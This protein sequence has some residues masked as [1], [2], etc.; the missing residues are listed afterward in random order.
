MDHEVQNFQEDVLNASHEKPVLVDFWAA[1]CGPCQTLGPIL[2]KLE[3][4]QSESWTLVKIDTDNNR[5]VSAR[6]KIQGIPAVKLFIDGEVVD[7]FTG[8]L[9]EYAVKQWLEKAIP[10]ENRKKLV[11]A[12]LL[13]GSDDSDAAA[14]I[15]KTVLEDEPTNPTP[16]G[17]LAGI[18]A[19]SEPERATELATLARTGE[20]RFVQTADAILQLNALRSRQNEFDSIADEQGK[21]D[22][23]LALNALV[24]GDLDAALKAFIK[25]IIQNRYL[26]DDAS[27]KAC[28]AIFVLLGE[29][30]PLTRTHRRTFDM[31][32]Y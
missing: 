21:E 19:F 8:A 7:E 6:Y 4:E 3:S 9:P 16:A 26:D 22:Y 30:H 14:L 11:E 27:R 18:L 5:E 17:L 32:L 31:S 23:I 2:E 24:R 28:V 29:L 13:I 12:E 25:V 15:L 1:W 20:P 10:T